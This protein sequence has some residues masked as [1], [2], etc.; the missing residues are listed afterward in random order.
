VATTHVLPFC[1][2]EIRAP[3]PRSSQYPQ[4]IS[5]LGDHI[6]TRRLDL[7]LLQRQVADQI[8][9]HPLTITNWESNES[10]PE[11]HFIPAVIEFLGYD[12]LPPPSSLPERLASRRRVLG[13][14]Q[15][16]MAERMGVDPDTLRGWEAG[17]H[18]PTGKSL[19]GIQRALGNW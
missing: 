12:P 5:T 17:R 8:G 9:V 7:K 10:S 11:T 18:Q 16:E 1:H 19:D 13:L 6:R 2:F 15:R 4:Q 3:R 14:S